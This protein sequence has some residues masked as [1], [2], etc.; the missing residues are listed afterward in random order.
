MR[1]DPVGRYTIAPIQIRIFPFTA[2]WVQGLT[3]I[4]CEKLHKSNRSFRVNM[5]TGIV[6][7][8]IG[9]TLDIEFPSDALPNILNAVTVF[10][11]NS[12]ATLTTEV[13]QHLGNNLV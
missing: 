12:G 3:Q 9:P 2:S 13:A 11:P 8:V 1:I 5:A 4:A 10:D 7:Q 6:K